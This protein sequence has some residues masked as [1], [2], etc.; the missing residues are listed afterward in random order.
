MKKRQISVNVFARHRKNIEFVVDET[1][2]N[3]E[4]NQYASKY[5]GCFNIFIANTRNFPQRD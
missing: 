5:L 2:G 4:L 1:T 3:D